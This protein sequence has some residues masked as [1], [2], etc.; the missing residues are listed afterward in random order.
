MK[1]AADRR[2]LLLERDEGGRTKRHGDPL[3]LPLLCAAV[4]ARKVRELERRRP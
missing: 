2:L 4:E 3:R 1:A